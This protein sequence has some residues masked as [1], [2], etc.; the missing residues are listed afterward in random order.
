MGRLVIENTFTWPKERLAAVFP[1]VR[2]LV[3]RLCADFPNDLTEEFFLGEAMIGKK[4]LWVVY[5]EDA[6]DKAVIVGFTE[7]ENNNPT[8]HKRVQYSGLCGDRLHEVLP[9]ILKAFEVW[10]RER[11]AESGRVV[12]RRGWLPTLKNYG[13][14]QTAVILTK[15]FGDE[16]DAAV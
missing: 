5:D 13:Y 11:G 8:G 4:H 2:K 10:G 7:M 12:G 9:D 3:Q 6:P 1:S 14:Q 16:A 15:D